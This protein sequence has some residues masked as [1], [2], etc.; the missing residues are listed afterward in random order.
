VA[1]QSKRKINE[2]LK[3]LPAR[4]DEHK[5]QIQQVSR[6]WTMKN[7]VRVSGDWTIEDAVIAKDAAQI[8]LNNAKKQ[9]TEWK[10]GQNKDEIKK[11]KKLNKILR[12][13]TS[14]FEKEKTAESRKHSGRRRQIDSLVDDDLRLR[15]DIEQ[16]TSRLEPLRDEYKE[17][18]AKVFKEKGNSCNYCGEVIVCGH[19]DERDEDAILNFNK[20]KKRALE[21]INSLGRSISASITKSKLAITRVET[22]KK[23]LEAIEKSEIIDQDSTQEMRDLKS[24]IKEIEDSKTN[25]DT[26]KSFLEEV[27]KRE[28]ELEEAMQLLATIKSNSQSDKRVKDLEVRMKTLSTE[29]NLIEKFLFLLD[30]YNQKLAEATEEP[31]NLLFEHSMFKMFDRQING[32]ILPTCDIMNKLSAPYETALSS[33]EKI[34]IGL[35]IIKTMSKHYDLYAPLFIDGAESL[36]TIPGMDCQTIELVTSAEYETLT[37]K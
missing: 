28:I 21:Q 27:E 14:E 10:N 22:E 15:K 31:V 34:F 19:C 30:K 20:Y 9:I 17:E 18:A 1:I 8:N 6:D 2:E 33:G 36:T 12:T 13:K 3:T 5:K 23:E 37:Q 4:I 32:A 16:K 7:G 11:I 25:L 26:P 24:S 35:D 29:F